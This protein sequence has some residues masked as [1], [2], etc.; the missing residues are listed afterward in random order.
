MVVSTLIVK[1]QLH[2]P[3]SIVTTWLPNVAAGTVK[4]ALNWPPKLEA[5]NAPFALRGVM[6]VNGRPVCAGRP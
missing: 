1:F 2:E 3:S 4:E 6:K 5:L